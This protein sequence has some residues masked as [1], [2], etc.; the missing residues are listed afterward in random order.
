MGGIDALAYYAVMHYAFA[1][2]VVVFVCVIVVVFVLL[3]VAW[4]GSFSIRVSRVASC[5]LRSG[6]GKWGEGDAG[7]V[8]SIGGKELINATRSR[9]AK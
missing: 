1:V 6:T 8:A 7:Y 9:R 2:I 3:C 5:L 4:E